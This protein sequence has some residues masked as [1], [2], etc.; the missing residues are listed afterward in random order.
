MA[1]AYSEYSNDVLFS[2]IFLSFITASSL[3]V[4]PLSPS[5]AALRPM[6]MVMVLIFWLIFQSRHV[7]LKTAFAI[8]IIID[9]LMDSRLGQ[10][11]FAAV[12]VVLAIN[13]MSKYIKSLSIGTAWLMAALG[14]IT[15]QLCLWLLQLMIQNSAVSPSALPLLT[16]IISWPLILLLLRR[17]R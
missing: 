6:L 3:S 9:L 7:G 2:I 15:Y 14:L 11:A 1:Q 10:H 4:Y 12:L 13:L 16:S 8:G 5:V 17:F